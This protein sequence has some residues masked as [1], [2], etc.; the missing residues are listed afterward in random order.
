MLISS[1]VKICI[2]QLGRVDEMV[3]LPYDAGLS[4]AAETLVGILKRV[5]VSPAVYPRF[6]EI[7]ELARSLCHSWAT[8][9]HSDALA[10]SPKRQSTR[11][12]EIKNGGL[13][14]YDKVWSLKG[15]VERISTFLNIAHQGIHL[16]LGDSEKI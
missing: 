11:M 3:W 10:L 6:L 13:D 9:W 2:Q 4:A 5:I 1:T 12:S 7:A 8:C 15:G 16:C 14:Q